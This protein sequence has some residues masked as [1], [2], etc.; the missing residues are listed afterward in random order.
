MRAWP[1]ARPRSPGSERRV[2]TQRLEARQRCV[3]LV[4][5][6][7]RDAR[8]ATLRVAD[9]HEVVALEGVAAGDV[10]VTA[11]ARSAPLVSAVQRLGAT[12]PA[13]AGAN[14]ELRG[15]EWGRSRR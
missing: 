15:Y 4:E 5:L 6:E 13:R 10:A 2:R 7:Q 8:Q 3:E 9:L 11:D 12:R 1:P 14:H